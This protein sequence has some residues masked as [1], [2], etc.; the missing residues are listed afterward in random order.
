MLFFNRQR[1]LRTWPVLAENIRPE[2]QYPSPHRFVGDIQTALGGQIFGRAADGSDAG[3]LIGITQNDRVHGDAGSLP[4]RCRKGS[5]YRESLRFP[6]APAL[7]YS[8]AGSVASGGWREP[9]PALR[10]RNEGSPFHGEKVS[11]D[12]PKAAEG[13]RRDNRRR[14]VA[15]DDQLAQPC[16]VRPQDRQHAARLDH[17]RKPARRSRRQAPRL[18]RA[19]ENQFRHSGGRAEYRRRGDR[20]LRP[21]RNRPGFVEP[22]ADA[23]RLAGHSRDLLRGRRAGAPLRV[24]FAAARADPHTKR[25]DRT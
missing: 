10:R 18:F 14:R 22:I 20:R 12:T 25:H 1:R 24:L 6:T 9:R 4:V 7:L 17:R 15:F 3:D 11:F 21:L 2:I 19:R 5:A 8:I 16:S 23:R 13:C